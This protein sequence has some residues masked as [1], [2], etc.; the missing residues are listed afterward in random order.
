VGELPEEARLADPGFADHC[1]D[2]AVPG[3]GSLQGLAELLQLRVAPD[4]ACQAA[5]SGRLQPRAY[6]ARADNLKDLE[7]DFQAFDRSLPEGLHRHV[8]FGQI[9]RLGRDED[10][11]RHG[12]LLQARR[13][14]RR[15]T[16]GRVV[17]MKVA[18]NR[19]HNDLAGVHADPD[20]Q[21]HA[22][23]PVHLLR[24]SFHRFLHPQRGVA[25]PHGMILVGE[26]G[27][28]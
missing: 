23:R 12:H 3:A 16:D 15:L 6:D 2:L 27:A 11:P 24:V 13:Q 21:R 10:G 18:P 4:E 9:Q 19:T 7:T 14:V 20:M 17:H 28:E 22:R 8:A 26:R 25:G 1:H 5:G